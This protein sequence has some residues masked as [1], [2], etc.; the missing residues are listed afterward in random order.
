MKTHELNV[1][2]RLIADAHFGGLSFVKV[3]RLTPTQI[4]LEK[5]VKVR[6]PFV[7]RC[8]AIGSTGWSKT[9]YRIPTEEDE[10]QV[11]IQRIARSLA[12]VEWTKI[13]LETLAKINGMLIDLTANKS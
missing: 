6:R 2:D 11:S 1:G 4:V 10:R 12:K 5:D 9:Y 8:S 7:D 13:P 3:V